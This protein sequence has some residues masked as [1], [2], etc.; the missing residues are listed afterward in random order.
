MPSWPELKSVNTLSDI[1]SKKTIAKKKG[2]LDK[3]FALCQAG[4]TIKL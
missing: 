4:Q 1:L 2:P 3:A